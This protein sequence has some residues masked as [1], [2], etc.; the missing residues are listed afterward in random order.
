[1]SRKIKVSP[2]QKAI[3]NIDDNG[4]VTYL[5]NGFPQTYDEL[6][7]YSPDYED[8][9][10][11]DLD[12]YTLIGYEP[13]TANQILEGKVEKEDNRTIQLSISDLEKIKRILTAIPQFKDMAAAL[14][15]DI[16]NIEGLAKVLDKVDL[17]S[18]PHFE[19]DMSIFNIFPQN[20]PEYRRWLFC[21]ILEIIHNIGLTNKFP[22]RRYLKTLLP[23]F[24]DDQVEVI[25]C[26]I[27]R[28]LS[29]LNTWGGEFKFTTLNN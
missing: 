23:D 21:T 14:E 16:N 4:N 7:T 5:V 10:L 22:S 1:M 29:T 3:F 9:N 15:L 24:N 27:K 28:L 6:L 25:Y 18:L 8:F 2:D 11:E 26:L 20:N 12:P 13:E 17:M 19:V